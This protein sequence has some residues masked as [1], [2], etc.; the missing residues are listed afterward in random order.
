MTD[1]AIDAAAAS[2]STPPR[3]EPPA[4]D[5]PTGRHQDRQPP[6]TRLDPPGQSP[7]R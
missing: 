6:T 2:Y 3:P 7:S 1:R 4:G 5:G